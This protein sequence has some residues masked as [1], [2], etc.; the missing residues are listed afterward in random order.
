VQFLTFEQARHE[1]FQTEYR[2]SAVNSGIALYVLAALGAACVYG[3]RQAWIEDAWIG[4]VIL[5]W[6][7]FW[8]GLFALMARRVHRARRLPSNWL[9]R[10]QSGGLL[11]QFRSYLNHHF[12]SEDA[13]IVFLSFSDIAWMRRHKVRRNV[14][15]I[16]RADDTPGNVRYA[17]FKLR[18]ELVPLLDA[19]LR[20]ERQKKGPRSRRLGGGTIMSRHYPLQVV[21]GGLVRI[22]WNVR[23][24]LKVF[25]QEMERRIEVRAPLGSSQDYRLL[26]N[27]SKEEQ[28]KRLLELVETGDT[29]GAIKVAKL[30]YNLDTT[31]AKKFVNEFSRRQV[32]K[33]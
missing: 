20:D 30:L 32:S 12:S 22:E 2:Y 1:P 13:S 6:L 27:L 18:D 19:R 29:I 17:E 23:P 5:G 10:V 28:E 26:Q 21:Q 4:T 7:A 25:L 8:F 14:P 31:A 24:R 16:T 11:I 15:G 3:A 9:V 33:L